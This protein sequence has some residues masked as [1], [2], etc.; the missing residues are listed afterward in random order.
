MVCPGEQKK[1]NDGREGGG[2]IQLRTSASLTVMHFAENDEFDIAD[3]IRALIE[4][5]P[6]N[7]RGHDQAAASRV[8]LHIPG[9]DPHRIRTEGLLEI[10]NFWLR[11]L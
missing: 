8:D 4:H 10:P 2:G 1:A 9:Q 7:L 6:E 5:T 3:E 11:A